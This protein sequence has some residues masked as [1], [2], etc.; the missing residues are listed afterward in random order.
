MVAPRTY[1]QLVQ[2]GLKSAMETGEALMTIRED[3][4]YRETHE[5][6]ESYCQEKWGFSPRTAHG[7]IE[8]A[9]G[10]K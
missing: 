9:R 8:L 6:F 4:L 3:H 2:S 5:T 1:K 10:G 7:L